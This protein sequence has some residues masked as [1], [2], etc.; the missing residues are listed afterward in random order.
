MYVVDTVIVYLVGL[1]NAIGPSNNRSV[2]RYPAIMRRV[3]CALDCKTRE[4]SDRSLS[5]L[6][7][8]T[9]T[10]VQPGVEDTTLPSWSDQAQ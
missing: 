4:P 6:S 2:R 3:G 9:R 10:W 5:R 8:M 7:F 1:T